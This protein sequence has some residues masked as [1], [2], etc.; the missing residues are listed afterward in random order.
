MERG[1]A[2]KPNLTWEEIGELIDKSGEAA[3]AAYK[4]YRFSRTEA[5]FST[6]QLTNVF[7]PEYKSN[8]KIL[9]FDLETSPN[10]SWTWRTWKENIAYDQILQDWFILTFSAK[11]LW[12]EKIMSERLTPEEVLAEDDSRIVKLLWELVNEADIIVAHN[13]INF[14]QKRMNTRFL[15]N[16]LGIPKPYQVVDTLVHARKHLAFVSNRLDALGQI[17]NV[18]K[19][20]DTGGFL[21]WK[22]CM[23]GDE[24]A[25]KK[26]EL[27]NI[28]DVKLLEDVYT[29]LMS[30]I[31][32]HPNIGLLQ[33]NNGKLVCATCG[34]DDLHEHGEYVTTA[35]VFQAY[36][37][38]NCGSLSR[39]RK[40]LLSGTQKDHVTIS[41]PK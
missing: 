26:M 18:G 39:S 25:L 1:W 13:A 33:P 37:C 27:Y 7:Y 11:W 16:G 20:V 10:L 4:R 19:K 41:I 12:E 21:L 17:L 15:L 29:L 24:E 31:K 40:Q 6:T 28:G 30:Y 5:N 36:K 22:Q 2:S 9:I 23:K 32:P 35:S 14:D 34:S 38:G 3:R 8:A